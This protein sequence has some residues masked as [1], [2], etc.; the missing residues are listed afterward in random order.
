MRVTVEVVGEATHTVELDAPTYGDLLREVGLNHHE[1]TALV[2]GR[3]VPEDAP[4]DAERV[5]V[6]RLIKGG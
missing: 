4:A 5:R 3:P 1:A 6:L 2:D